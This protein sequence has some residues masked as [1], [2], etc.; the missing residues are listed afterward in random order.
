MSVQPYDKEASRAWRMRLRTILNTEWDPI[1]N[2][3]DDEYDA[4]AGKIAA[5]VRDGNSNQELV[6]YLR[7]AEVEHIEMPGDPNR[8]PSVVASIRAL[9][10]LK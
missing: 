10:P 6:D 7:W 3:P 2:C 9:G 8:L 4:Y 1:G 5:M